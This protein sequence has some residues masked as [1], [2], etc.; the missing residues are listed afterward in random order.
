[1]IVV[2]AAGGT[3]AHKKLTATG[4]M[5]KVNIGWFLVR[6]EDDGVEEWLGSRATPSTTTLAALGASTWTSRPVAVSRAAERQR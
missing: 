6:Y 4:Q 2:A 5:R 1:M 3:D